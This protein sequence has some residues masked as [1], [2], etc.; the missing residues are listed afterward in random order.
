MRLNERYEV[1]LECKIV[2]GDGTAMPATLHDISFGGAGLYVAEW[3]G[4]SRFDVRVPVGAD[5]VDFQAELRHVTVVWNRLRLHAQ[6]PRLSFSQQRALDSLIASAAG[7]SRWA[8]ASPSFSIS[9]RAFSTSSPLPLVS[10]P[11]PT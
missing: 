6:F 7:T 10:C 1:N 3:P 8:L 4:W 9:Q 5:W 2:S 11:R